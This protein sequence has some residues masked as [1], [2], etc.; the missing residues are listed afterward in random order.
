M[1]DIFEI[2]DFGYDITTSTSPDGCTASVSVGNKVVKRFKGETA[3]S[4]AHRFATDLMFKA[5]VSKI[6]IHLK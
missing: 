1:S 2:Q 4:K 5:Q 3:H 6:S